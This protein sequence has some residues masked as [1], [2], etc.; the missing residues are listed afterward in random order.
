ALGTLNA[1]PPPSQRGAG[2]SP[3]ISAHVPELMYAPRG[4]Q[5]PGPPAPGPAATAEP[6]SCVAG[7]TTCAGL[8]PVSVAI[9]GRSGPST[10]PGWT[11]VPRMCAG[12]SNALTSGNAHIFVV[13]S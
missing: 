2:S 4:D 13:G 12:S 9:A 5:P 8:M 3:P 1:L 10:V 7:T 6:V 11:I